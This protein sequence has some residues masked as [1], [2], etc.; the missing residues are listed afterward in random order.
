MT[1]PLETVQEGG[2]ERSVKTAGSGSDSTTFV[3]VDG[4]AL[5][6]TR[7][8]VKLLVVIATPGVAALET[9]KSAAGRTAVTSEVESL[10]GLRSVAALEIVAVLVM[11][12]TTIGLLAIRTLT[13]AL[14]ATL[15]NVHV[16]IPLD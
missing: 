1:T 14:T 9:A 10:A 3:A 6:T 11:L 7:L 2:T 5:V 4:P 15:A 8:N 13:L 12:P 16:T